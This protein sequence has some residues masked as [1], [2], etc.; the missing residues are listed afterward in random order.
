MHPAQSWERVSESSGMWCFFRRRPP[1]R[2][3]VIFLGECEPWPL[4][5]YAL[6]S[7]LYC[8]L[9][10]FFQSFTNPNCFSPWFFDWLMLLSRIWG[11][12]LIDSSAFVLFFWWCWCG[13][14][15]QLSIY[16]ENSAEPLRQYH[17]AFAVRAEQFHLLWHQRAVNQ[18]GVR[19]QGS[20]QPVNACM[21]RPSISPSSLPAA[22]VR[23]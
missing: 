1:W 7:V 5:F 8:C 4:R 21:Q 2:A 6:S 20:C 22:S 16:F 13:K 15:C 12:S 18:R 14:D 10:C 11:L 17:Q 9:G 19:C 23:L 3:A